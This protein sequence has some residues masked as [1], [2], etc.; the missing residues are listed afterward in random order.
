MG[1]IDIDSEMLERILSE[2]DGY[3]QRIAELE[4]K[5]EQLADEGL[6]AMGIVRELE[7]ERDRLSGAVAGLDG[8][9]LHLLKLSTS[10]RKDNDRLSGECARLRKIAE[11]G[12]K[13]LDEMS[14]ADGSGH[15][16][17]ARI[18]RRDIYNE[19]SGEGASG[20]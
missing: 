9:E 4:A 2:R 1:E 19:G 11:C 13:W 7:A 5:V 15:S 18:L 17:L 8:N 12:A 14:S 3:V 16:D 20:G 10:L 6:K